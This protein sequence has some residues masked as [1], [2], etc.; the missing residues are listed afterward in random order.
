MKDSL[1]KQVSV[2][3][4][5][6]YAQTNPGQIDVI[7]SGYE[8]T[9]F[10]YTA[11]TFQVNNASMNDIKQAHIPNASL[12]DTTRNILK[13][14]AGIFYNGL[15][16]L[17]SAALTVSDEVHTIYVDEIKKAFLMYIIV[18]SCIG[19]G[20]VLI[21]TV[22]LIPTVFKV[23]RTTRLVITLFGMIDDDDIVALTDRCERFTE[24]YLNEGERKKVGEEEHDKISGN[25]KDT[26]IRDNLTNKAPDG[27]AIGGSGLNIKKD[28]DDNNFD[29][30]TEKLPTLNGPHGIVLSEADKKS[31]KREGQ[32]MKDGGSEQKRN[33]LN[34]G[35]RIEDEKSS[36]KAPTLAMQPM[37]LKENSPK[38]NNAKE[39]RAKNKKIS[40]ERKRNGE[41]YFKF[42]LARMR[43]YP[44]N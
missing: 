31:M 7:K 4:I 6:N 19:M 41:E 28:E 17:R 42:T 25:D 36:L 26:A 14:F 20:L 35:N 43:T 39:K 10:Q 5:S 15:R 40:N 38:K 13:A 11:E 1:G 16:D 12:N 27:S 3:E 23:M 34:N 22:L 2:N 24:E 30:K 21:G 18:L 37:K 33:L 44:K 8:S 29:I 9:L 32:S